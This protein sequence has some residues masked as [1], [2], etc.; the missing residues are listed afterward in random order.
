MERAFLIGPGAIASDVTLKS[1][2]GNGG[3]YSHL[4]GRGAKCTFK[5]TKSEKATPHRERRLKLTPLGPIDQNRTQRKALQAAPRPIQ[6]DQLNRPEFMGL[7]V[8]LKPM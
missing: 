7:T 3:G 5:T 4:T 6:T 8:T 1:N 2:L